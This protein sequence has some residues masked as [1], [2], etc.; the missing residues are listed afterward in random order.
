MIGFLKD[1]G[2]GRKEDA[3]GEK[4]GRLSKLDL[5]SKTPKS[6]SV[7]QEWSG[8]EKNNSGDL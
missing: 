2:G 1:E 4:S 3:T 8:C 7:C 6:V 5:I